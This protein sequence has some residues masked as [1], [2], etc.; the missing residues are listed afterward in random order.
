VW[1]APLVPVAIAFTAGIVIDRYWAIPLLFSLS[2]VPIFLAACGFASIG[3]TKLAALPYLLLA[4][5]AIGAGYHRLHQSVF[6]TREIG[7]YATEEP[8][9]I[10]VRGVLDEEP[11]IAYQ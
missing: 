11:I 1:R 6:S 10:R 4:T 7:N 3:R 5:T 2:A 8:R 9:L